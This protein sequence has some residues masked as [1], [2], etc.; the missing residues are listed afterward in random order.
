MSVL[1]KETDVEPMINMSVFWLR[2]K[3][4]SGGGI[5]FIKVGDNGAVRYRREDVEAFISS[6]VRKSTSDNGQAV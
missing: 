3:R 6:R 2:R 5:P 4:W 1:L